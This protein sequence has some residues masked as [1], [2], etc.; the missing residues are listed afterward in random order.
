MHP[1]RQ[2]RELGRHSIPHVT[3]AVTEGSPGTVERS[4]DSPCQESF[5]RKAEWGK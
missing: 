2:E 1:A 4:G 3:A 5:L